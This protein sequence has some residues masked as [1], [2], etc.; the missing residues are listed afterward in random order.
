MMRLNPRLGVAVVIATGAWMVTAALDAQV[1]GHDPNI[2]IM[3]NCADDDPAWDAFGGCPEEA[4]FPGSNSYRGDVPLAEFFSVETGQ[5]ACEGELAELVLTTLGRAGAPVIRY[6]TGDVVRPVWSAGG[7]NNFV[8]LEGG[9]LGRTDDMMIIRGVN[10]FP[11][12]VEQIVRS[13]PE[14]IEY[15]LTAHKSGAMDALTVE[16]EDRLEQ[17]GRV[18]QEFQVRLGLNVEVQCVPFAS[19]P[20]FEGKGNRFID[21]R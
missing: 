16:I 1:R 17:P 15:R 5:P 9:V 7:E 8:L 21:R 19:L 11:S 13:F 6:R 2:A 14:I 20:R 18:V 3:D 12:S 10:V 4:P